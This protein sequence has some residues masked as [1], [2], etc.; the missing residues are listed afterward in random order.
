MQKALFKLADIMDQPDIS[1]RNP[2]SSISFSCL[3]EPAIQ[4]QAEML[5][6]Y[7][8]DSENNFSPLGPDGRPL[9][10]YVD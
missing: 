4:R 9:R 7:T 5:R 2:L 1:T 10:K 3:N 8:E 6:E